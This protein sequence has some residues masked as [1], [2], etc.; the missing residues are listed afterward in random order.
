VEMQGLRVAVRD[1]ARGRSFSQTRNP[2]YHSKR[3]LVSKQTIKLVVMMS[4][5]ET[6]KNAGARS[7]SRLTAGRSR[8][9]DCAN[10]GNLCATHAT[11]S[12]R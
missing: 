10:R 5:V 3:I 4:A 12:L 7:L 8:V 2:Y 9:A 11:R 1:V 6:W